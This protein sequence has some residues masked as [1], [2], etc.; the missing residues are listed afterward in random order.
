MAAVIPA[1]ESTLSKLTDQLKD[2]NS[3]LDALVGQGEDQIKAGEDAAAA[4]REAA[5]EAARRGDEPLELAVTVETEEDEEGFMGAAIGAISGALLGAAAGLTIGFVNMWTDIFKFFKGKFIKMF[6]DFTKAVSDIFGKE[7][8]ISKVF[9]SI[10]N[11]FKNNKAF[12][13]MDDLITKGKAAITK[14]MKP[15]KAA[16]TSMKTGFTTFITK[17]KGWIKLISG[18]ID[19]IKKM[20]GVGAKAGAG[21]T[22]GMGFLK[23]FKTFFKIFKTFFAKLFVPLQVIISLVEGFFEAKDAV[24]KSEGMMATF[25]NAIV[26]FFGGILD[27]LIFGMLDLI[28]DGIS[29]IAGFL[30]FEDVEKF[31]DSFSFSKMFNEFLDDIYEW[32]NLLFQDPVKA[33][34]NLL[35]GYFGTML[36]IG[37]F[38]VDMLKKPFVWIMELFGWDDAAAATESFSLSGTVMDAWNKV[39]AWVKSLFAWGKKAGATEEGGWSL[40]TF[41]NGVWTKVKGWFTSL[42]SWASS[43]DEGDSWIVKTIKGVVKTVK[44]WFGSMFKFD[45]A[46]DLLST[47]MNIMM[48]IPNLFVKA[49]AGIASFFAGLLGFDEESEA[50]ANAGKEFSFGDLI[51]KGV[52]AIGKWF[53]DL[54]D[55]IVNFDFKSLAKSIMPDFL[56]DMIF[57]KEE[58][59]AKKTE[60]AQKVDLKKV[61]AEASDSM[62]D[63]GTLMKPIRDKVESILDPETAPWG[64]GKFSG[65]M[66]DKLLAMLPTAMA[67]GGLVGLS[68]MGAQSMG[69]AMGLESGGLFTLSQGEFVLD[70]QAA[71]TF[72]QAATILKGQDLSGPD[73]AKLQRE[74]VGAS[75]QVSSAPVV[76]SAPQS[77]T[78]NSSSGV[79]LPALPIAPSNGQSQLA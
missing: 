58:P 78:V 54:F 32:F 8:K 39:V 31:L 75:M 24:G 64:L 16:F 21:G 37:D 43:E 66:R 62:F 19:S 48:W 49:I 23:S 6:P 20:L 74:S 51:M 41:V 42:F 26:G 40:L 13:V 36:S 1:S 30:G 35:S 25:F 72:L 69:A 17:I 79:M 5:R 47:V 38:I 9:T 60:A 67:E 55:S 63:L 73:L 52:K 76:I 68:P 18:P 34:T 22:G 44:D 7:G 77:T 28:K 59:K 10:K 45:S 70:N 14:V 4:A 46:S 29:W 57:G 53:G 3:K 65:F 27:G 2:Q 33:L 71:Q 50:I 15:I 61:D 56:A 12:Q 11:F